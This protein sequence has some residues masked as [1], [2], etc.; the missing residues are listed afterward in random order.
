MRLALNDIRP[1]MRL[2]VIDHGCCDP[3]ATRVH[4]LI[5]A[6]RE[7]GAEVVACGPSSIPG[8]AEQPPGLRGVHLHDIAAAN[9]RFLAAVRDGRPEVLLAALAR[10]SPGLLGLARE[11]ARQTIAEAVDAFD[12]DAIFVLHAGILAELAIETGVPVAVHVSA[13]DLDAADPREPLSDLVAAALGSAESI[14][15]ADSETARRLQAEWLDGDV[16]DTWP[17]D[18]TAAPRILAACRAAIA[19]RAM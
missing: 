10:V 3:P 19:R 11:A 2:V 12:P 17:I 7:A 5:S 1:R 13:A 9:R 8:L 4:A 6:L 18:S 15:A 14:I 16:C